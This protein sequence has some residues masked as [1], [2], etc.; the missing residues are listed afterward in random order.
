M[1][2][3]PALEKGPE[4]VALVIDPWQLRFASFDTQGC[5]DIA[6]ALPRCCPEGEPG[7]ALRSGVDLWVGRRLFDNILK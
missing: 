3:R 6:V 5:A 2:V 1:A 7:S 4:T